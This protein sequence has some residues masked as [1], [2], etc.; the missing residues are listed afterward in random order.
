MTTSKKELKERL[1][2]YKQITIRVIGR[3][4]GKRIS[5]PVWFV[6]E[7]ERITDE[8]VRVIVELGSLTAATNQRSSW[9][10]IGTHA[11]C[12]LVCCQ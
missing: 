2:R 3:K 12:T 10:R 9:T 11:P 1:G 8:A 5:L 7:G 4:S 6:L